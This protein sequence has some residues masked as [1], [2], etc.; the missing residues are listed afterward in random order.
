MGYG[1]HFN[2]I[3]NIDNLI[4]KGNIEGRKVALKVLEC[5]LK[6]VDAYA[7]VKRIVKIEGD[8]LLVGEDVFVLSELRDIYVLGAGKAAYEIAKA[9][10]EEL[11]ERIRDGVII[12]QRELAKETSFS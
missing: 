3:K 6:E 8:K 4:S 11:Q 2:M 10:E 5:A 1:N 12:E 7:L 9:L